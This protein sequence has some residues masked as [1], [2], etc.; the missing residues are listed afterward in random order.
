M[1]FI[2]G[3]TIVS[4]VT[5]G[6]TAAVIGRRAYRSFAGAV[7]TVVSLMA[8]FVSLE[9]MRDFLRR[10]SSSPLFHWRS[11]VIRTAI[12]FGALA[13]V[14]WCAGYVLG[15]LLRGFWDGK[16]FADKMLRGA[17]RSAGIGA[18]VGIAAVALE[19]MT[20]DRSGES[21]RTA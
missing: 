19:V 4:G 2:V 13:A 12:R 8:F 20:M 18:L 10:A 16:W 21:R 9:F 14:L 7:G 17:I 15:E 5:D 6:N 3:V 1:F 11:T